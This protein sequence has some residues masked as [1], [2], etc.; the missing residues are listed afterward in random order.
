MDQGIGILKRTY[1]EQFLFHFSRIDS[2]WF[3][4]PYLD[5]VQY[6]LSVLSTHV[7]EERRIERSLSW[8]VARHPC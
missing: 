4:L 6:L 5:S 8:A 1:N 7:S 2:V 3:R